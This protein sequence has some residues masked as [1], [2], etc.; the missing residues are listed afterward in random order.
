MVTKHG[1]CETCKK[2]GEEYAN[3]IKDEAVRDL[4]R[5]GV[6]VSKLWSHG[7]ADGEGTVGGANEDVEEEQQEVF[8][9][10]D[11]YAVVY[12]RAMMVHF[13][14]ATLANTAVVR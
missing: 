8:L 7:S 6:H 9:V 11:A 12:P 13:G 4:W 3:H 5:L 10:V 2:K 1:K 14:D